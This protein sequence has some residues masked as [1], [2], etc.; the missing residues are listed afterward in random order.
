M[1]V[2]NRPLATSS[3]NNF[4]NALA[5]CS[6]SWPLS[7]LQKKKKLLEF[8]LY[9]ICNFFADTEAKPNAT[10]P[11]ISFPESAFPFTS[12]RERRA[13]RGLWERGCCS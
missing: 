7:I 12:D 2:G 9:S 8:L 6:T 4:L 10:V 1:K 5:S 11:I 13:Q 3:G